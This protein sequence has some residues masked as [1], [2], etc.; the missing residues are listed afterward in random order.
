[1]ACMIELGMEETRPVVHFCDLLLAVRPQT[2]EGPLLLM[3][4]TVPLAL[5]ACKGVIVMCIGMAGC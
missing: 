5:E 2:G 3:I 1:M 4:A